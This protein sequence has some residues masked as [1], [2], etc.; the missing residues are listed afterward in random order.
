MLVVLLRIVI[1]IL[2]YW[3]SKSIGDR[4]GHSQRSILDQAL[5]LPPFPSL[6]YP[7]FR[8]P[9][10]FPFLLPWAFRSI[11][12]S[13]RGPAAPHFNSVRGPGEAPQ[14]S[15]VVLLLLLEGLGLK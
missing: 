8:Y 2:T 13:S 4:Q 12:S 11:P 7:A 6:S 1:S 5:L 3:P 15:F 10:L 14:H 9:Q